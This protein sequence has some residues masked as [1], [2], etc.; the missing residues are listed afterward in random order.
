M[1][2]K[3]ILHFSLG[4]IGSAALGLITLPIVTWFFSTEDI[5]RLTMLQVSISFT[6]LLFT[7]GLDQAFVR[8]YHE[9]GDKSPLLKATILPGFVVLVAVLILLFVLPWSLYLN[10]AQ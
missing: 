6:L 4:P 7:L 10:Y 9:V 3:Q 2:I 8:E 5:G 1:N